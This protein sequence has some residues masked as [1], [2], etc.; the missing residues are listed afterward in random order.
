M[1]LLAASF[2]SDLEIPEQVA[3]FLSLYLLFAIGLKGGAALAENE[4]AGNVFLV[5][6]A[7]VLLASLIPV[8]MFFAL[9]KRLSLADAAAT[10]ATYGS[11]SAVTFVT[12]TSYLDVEGVSWQGYFVAAMALMESPAIIDGLMITYGNPLSLTNFSASILERS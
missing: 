9:R 6:G 4:L 1:G 11:V 10:A 2:R 12:A 8:V 5:L 3:K 7:A